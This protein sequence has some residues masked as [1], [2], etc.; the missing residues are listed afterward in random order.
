[1]GGTALNRHGVYTVRKS[2]DEFNCIS[3]KIN[4]LLL[5]NTNLKFYITKSYHTKDSFGDMDILIQTND[6]FTINIRDLIITMF[7]PKA[8]NSN[9]GVYSFDYDNFQIDFILINE[10]YWDVAKTYYSYDP[11]GNAMGK[12]YHKFNLKYG[13]DGLKYYYRNIYDKPN[14]IIL[15]STNP[16]K[17][18]EFADYDYD[19]YLMGFDTLEEIYEYITSSKYFD[20]NIFKFE[21]LTQIDRKRN[22]KRKSYGIMLNYFI[23]NHND[24]KYNFSLNKNEY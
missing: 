23:N 10:I 13:W 2:K 14:D 15:I 9:G 16:R 19:R 5:S 6:N 7:N 11:L 8:I 24:K 3:E 21:N 22:R 17:I 12:I 4:N 18:F 1:M 20:V